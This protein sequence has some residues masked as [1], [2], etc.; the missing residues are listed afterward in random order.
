[1]Q[2]KR[3]SISALFFFPFSS[4]SSFSFF[5]LFD[6]SSF[7]F[8]FLFFVALFET[9]SSLSP[10]LQAGGFPL[11]LPAAKTG[12]APERVNVRTTNQTG[13]RL[14]MTTLLE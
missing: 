4:S 8:F 13:I 9:R 5:P 12:T 7:F 14:I 1:V 3:L 11:P 10:L 6:F 2:I